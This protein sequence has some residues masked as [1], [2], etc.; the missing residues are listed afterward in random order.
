MNDY[1]KLVYK[2]AA[3]HDLFEIRELEYH[4]RAETEFSYSDAALINYLKWRRSPEGFSDQVRRALGYL[5]IC[6]T[7]YYTFM[8]KRVDLYHPYSASK[9]NGSSECC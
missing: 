4:L 9:P 6:I 1:A 8:T 3:L 5:R 7:C 2:L